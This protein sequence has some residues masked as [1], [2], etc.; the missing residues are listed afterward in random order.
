ML[1]RSLLSTS[2]LLLL[3]VSTRASEDIVL[4]SF[5]NDHV[6]DE[7]NDPVMGGRST[8]SFEQ[9][10]GLGTMQGHVAIVP[11][12]R[13]PGFIKAET[14]KGEDW[15]DLTSCTGLR[16]V[17]RSD[18]PEYEGF[19]FSFGHDKPP[20]RF[21]YSYGYKARFEAPSESGAVEFKFTDFSY[22]WDP[23]TGD[24]VTTCAENPDNCPKEDTLKNIYSV[25]V[26]GEGVEG[27]VHLQLSA[28]LAT[29]C[30]G[31][32]QPT[33]PVVFPATSPSSHTQD[34]PVLSAS[35]SGEHDSEG[36]WF[37]PAKFGL[38]VVC[39]LTLGFICR[40]LGRTLFPTSSATY[41]SIKHASTVVHSRPKS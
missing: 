12:L 38:G 19:R 31:H 15:P 3:I 41:S 1:Y 17:C 4:V 28:I 11:F 34:H 16:I 25:A 2:C 6:W 37:L 10:D 21:P 9:N 14:R 7:M 33:D 36:P 27:D 40:K 18:T 20:H 23:G 29:G 39:G 35:L 24:Q 26:W 13:A 8:G 22:D 5:E 30:D 32:I